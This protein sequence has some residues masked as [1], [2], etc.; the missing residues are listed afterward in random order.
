[1]QKKPSRVD[2]W[3]YF[4]IFDYYVN[5]KVFYFAYFSLFFIYL[6][7][8]YLHEASA[9]ITVLLSIFEYLMFLKFLYVLDVNKNKFYC[10]I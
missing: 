1:M 3:G 10:N 4:I 9:C 5:I 8:F 2:I 7:P 6:F